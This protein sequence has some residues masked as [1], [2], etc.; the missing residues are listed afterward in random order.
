MNYLK[1]AL[2]LVLMGAGAAGVIYYNRLVAK[3]A[4]AEQRINTAEANAAAARREAQEAKRELETLS[5][6]TVR[7][8]EFDA[9]LREA[10]RHTEQRL[11]HAAQNDPVARDYLDERIPDSVR[12][13]VL[14]PVR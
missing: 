8:A 10:R 9:A 7:R 2:A 13:A 3:V 5:R 12:N 4:T 6:E 11:D 1:L 14:P